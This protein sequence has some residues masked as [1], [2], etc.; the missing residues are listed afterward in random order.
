MAV[1]DAV[2]EPPEDRPRPRTS[3]EWDEVYTGAPPWDT[4]RP[5]PAIA[6]LAHE[7]MLTG[8]VLDI[9]CGTGEHALLAASLGCD[10]VGIDASA[11]A[12]AIAQRKAADRGLRAR[13]MVGDALRL[14]ELD[15]R[16][17]AVID[18]GLFHVFD[19]DDRPR[20]VGGLHHVLRAGGVLH[21]LCFS[22]AQPGTWGPRRV[23]REE[24]INS[25]TDGWDV[26]SIDA[27]TFEVNW[28]M[29]TAQA[30]LAQ[31]RRV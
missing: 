16:F 29:G 6:Q 8:R 18:S 30:W 20:Y 23:T 26:V 24:L 21:L 14:H 2:S 5:Q 17:D 11:R 19:D 10:A 1:N 27:A 22:D 28:E 12:I 25:F 3:D 13:F 31:I 4:G 7:E 9:G 15:E